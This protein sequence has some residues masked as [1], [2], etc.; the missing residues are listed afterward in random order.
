[1]AKVVANWYCEVA[2]CAREAIVV[3]STKTP[4]QVLSFFSQQYSEAIAGKQRGGA[5]ATHAGAY[6]YCIKIPLAQILNPVLSRHRSDLNLRRA[7]AG[8]TL[9]AAHACFFRCSDGLLS[10]DIHEQQ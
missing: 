2:C 7:Q 6:H 10:S 5:N 3:E 9:P 1:L 4:A 8:D